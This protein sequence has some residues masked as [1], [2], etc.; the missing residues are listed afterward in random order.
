MNERAAWAR[1]IFLACVILIATAVL[2]RE[3]HTDLDRL[4]R[5]GVMM[6]DDGVK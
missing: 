3:L 1:T 5:V 2:V 6:L 4:W